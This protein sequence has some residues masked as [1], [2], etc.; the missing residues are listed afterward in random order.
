MVA[1]NTNGTIRFNGLSGIEFMNGPKLYLP[2]SVTD[3]SS[4]VHEVSE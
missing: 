4:T 1:A 3:Q 2:L